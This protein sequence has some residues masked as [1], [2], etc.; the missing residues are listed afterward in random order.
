MM[1]VAVATFSAAFI[2][3]L[4]KSSKYSQETYLSATQVAALVNDDGS[5][6]SGSLPAIVAGCKQKAYEQM[7]DELALGVF[8]ISEKSVQ[9]RKVWRNKIYREA[10]DL[11]LID[12]AYKRGY[13]DAHAYEREVA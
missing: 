7:L 5:H 8:E 2:L 10:V 1:W 12:K 13:R 6:L 9:S 4:L 11:G 3:W